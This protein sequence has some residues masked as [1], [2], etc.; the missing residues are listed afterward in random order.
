MN[1]T[2]S[3]AA[4]TMQGDLFG[5]DR[6]FLGVSTDTRTVRSGELF[7]ALSGP[8]FDGG[9]FVAE[10][11]AKGA[12]G[13]V[14]AGRVDS[15]IAQIAVDDT[16]AALGR[17]G[18]AWR[19]QH[20]ATVVGVTGSNGKTTLKEM[21]AACL[22]QSAATIATAG[23]LNN[24][25]GMPLMLLRIDAS[26]RF[27]VIEMG[28]NHIGEIAYLTSLAKP[29][30]VVITNAGP[31]HLEGFGSLRGV[32]EG[33]G[34][35]L[36]GEQ[37]PRCAILNADDD[38]F[39]YWSSLVGDTEVLSF[40]LNDQA[41]VFAGQVELDKRG[42]TFRLHVP[43]DSFDVRLP[44]AGLHNVRNACAAAAVAT[45][46]D[47]APQDI[48]AALESIVPVSGRLQPAAGLQGATLFDDSYN[49]NPVSVAAAG[50][51]VAGLEGQSWMVLGDMGE[52]GEDAEELHRALGTTL[53]EQGID[54]LFAVGELSQATV[55]AFG[56]AGQWFASV[57]E[58]VDAVGA[59]MSA[60]VNVLVKGSR[61]AR[62]ERAVAGLR[63]QE[64]AR[65]EA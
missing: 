64:P 27:A 3:S 58:L 46:L 41:A 24:D 60:T 2:L 52:L 44:L 1:A 25:I 65:M 14:V 32:A 10:A 56:D 54:R 28:A 42:S 50:E 55:A 36:Q 48:R 34:E 39:D 38:F 4:A 8:N 51:F 59:Q 37:R 18:S 47:V 26:H 17:L 33:K 35:I 63:A 13:A 40:G 15:D 9:E 21:I 23:N 5:R 7:F 62:M 11:A 61:S 16:R 45:V 31:S 22:A 19:Q 6:T 20:A 49:A 43:G 30:V 53:R 29:D 57:D 12:A